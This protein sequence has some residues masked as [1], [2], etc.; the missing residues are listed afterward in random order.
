MKTYKT[1][2]YLG[3]DSETPEEVLYEGSDK[4]DAIAADTGG[5]TIE[6]WIDGE[7]VGYVDAGGDETNLQGNGFLEE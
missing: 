5:D 2:T 6:I 7:H 1:I 4:D 3:D